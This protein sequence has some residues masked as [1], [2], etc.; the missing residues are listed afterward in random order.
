[1]KKYRGIIIAAII[2]AIITFFIANGF[3]SIKN[4][5]NLAPENKE[6]I[7]TIKSENDIQKT[8]MQ[9][10]RTILNE[11]ITAQEKFITKTELVSEFDRMFTYFQTG[12]LLET[13]IDTVSITMN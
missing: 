2:S 10:T 5:V 7:V 8:Y 11:V 12:R 9:T 13:Q 6:E 4:R 3:D 1:M